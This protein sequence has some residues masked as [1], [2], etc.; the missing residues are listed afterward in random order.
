M[1][2]ADH[3]EVTAVEGG[4]RR[5]VESFG[6]GDDRGVRGTK[7]Q[8]AVLPHQLGHPLEIGWAERLELQL[9]GLES[10][11]Q[12]DLGCRTEPFSRQV[13]RFSE[14]QGGNDQRT[15]PVS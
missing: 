1:P 6:G 3:A 12:V 8:V 15:G 13:R 11:Q 10:G 2:G 9:G 7:R 14:T 5:H 4:D